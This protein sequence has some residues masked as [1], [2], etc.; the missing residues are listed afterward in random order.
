MTKVRWISHRR[1]SQIP[2]WRTA[3]EPVSKVC[4]P[5]QFLNVAVADMGDGSKPG[6][7]NRGWGG[8]S[9][10]PEAINQPFC[11][12][13]IVRHGLKQV[14]GHP[15]VSW[16]GGNRVACQTR[17][18]FATGA[19]GLHQGLQFCIPVAGYNAY[20]RSTLVVLEWTH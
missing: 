16:E 18:I 10:E 2:S 19:Q 7:E 11:Y 13:S 1:R 20:F 15:P 6:R 8:P 17:S 4:T 3:L 9:Q 14:Y 5:A 12:Y